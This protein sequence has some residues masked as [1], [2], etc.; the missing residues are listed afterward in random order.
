MYSPN[1]LLSHSSESYL[2][3]P[4]MKM[5]D[6]DLVTDRRNLRLLLGFAS[7][8]KSSLHVDVE[9]VNGTVL[10]YC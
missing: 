2:T 4:G 9:V 7:G 3:Q 6:I 1:V 10:F 8:R 5:N